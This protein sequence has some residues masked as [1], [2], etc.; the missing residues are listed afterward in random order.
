MRSIQH[1]HRIRA[2]SVCGTSGTV[3]LIDKDTQPLSTALMYDD[4]RAV[5]QAHEANRNGH[6]LWQRLG[7]SSIQTVWGLPKWMWL[8]ADL[9]NAL[10]SGCDM[11]DGTWHAG[12]MAELELPPSRLPDLVRPGTPI[13]TVC[14]A[15]A[16]H[17][18]LPA[19]IAI[20]AGMTDGC[21]SQ[22]ASGSVQTGSWN[23]VLGTTLVL[24]G[25]SP[26]LLRDPNGIVYSHRAPDGDWLPGGASS[27]G[28]GAFP[29]VLGAQ[30]DLEELAEAAQQRSTPPRIVYPLASGRGERF[31]FIAPDVSLAMPDCLAKDRIETYR[32]LSFGIA[33]VER[34]CFDYLEASGFPTHGPISLTGGGSRNHNL[35][36]LRATML[37]R[38][39]NVPTIA[40]PALGMALLASMI[41]S[42]IAQ[43]SERMVRIARTV[44][45]DAAQRA[46][47]SDYYVGFIDH[48]QSKGWL[49]RGI[50]DHARERAAA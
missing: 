36:R 44:E 9:S 43:A 50:A 40:E 8:P 4:G 14:S 35:N 39:L 33:A 23:S 42:P 34:L 6:A 48:L 1:P 45:P 11:I 18:G 41:E 28:A 15:A 22:L 7:Y 31:P 30:T 5:E 25:K 32:A 3:L 27:A 20:V 49:S 29:Q 2:L 17:T 38:R 24:K 10:K 26:S 46:Q 47:V 16:E 37:N 19:G 12:L 13:G 21:A